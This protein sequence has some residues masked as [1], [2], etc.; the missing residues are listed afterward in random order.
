M[1]GVAVP[2]VAAAPVAVPVALVDGPV[3]PVILATVAATAAAADAAVGVESPPA[4]P[5]GPGPVPVP[6]VLEAPTISILI[7][8][9]TD[10]VE[11]DWEFCVVE[12][13]AMGGPDG[14]V[15][16][17]RLVPVAEGTPTMPELPS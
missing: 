9:G 6:V 10:G 13:S 3:L 12:I 15:V 14:V 1:R 17:L 2:P 4:S 8:S 5:V 16:S 7:T 11:L